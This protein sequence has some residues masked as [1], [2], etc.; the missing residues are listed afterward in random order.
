MMS[1]A[2]LFLSVFAIFLDVLHASQVSVQLAKY[3]YVYLAGIVPSSAGPLSR[4]SIERV[5]Q[6]FHG[7]CKIVATENRFVE[8]RMPINI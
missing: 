3:F 4:K 1:R 6:C 8:A 2:V 5:L 7:W